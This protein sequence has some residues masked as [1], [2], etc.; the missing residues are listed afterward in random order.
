[1]KP[2]IKNYQTVH[3]STVIVTPSEKLSQW[4]RQN[5]HVSEFTHGPHRILSFQSWGSYCV[6]H[7]F[8]NTQMLLQPHQQLL[9]WVDLLRQHNPN[10]TESEYYDKAHDFGRFWRECHQACLH[11]SIQAS[12]Y[13]TDIKFLFEAYSHWL[14]SHQALD[15]STLFHDGM[16][17]MYDSKRDMPFPQVVFFG[18][19][20]LSPQ[21]ENHIQKLSEHTPCFFEY[22]I[23]YLHTH[24]HIRTSDDMDE[25]AWVA[26]CLKNHPTETIRIIVHDVTQ[27][28]AWSTYLRWQHNLASTAIHAQKLSALHDLKIIRSAIQVLTFFQPACSFFSRQTLLDFFQKQ[29]QHARILSRFLAH[30]HGHSQHCFAWEA[31]ERLLQIHAPEY[32]KNIWLKVRPSRMMPGHKKTRY[33]WCQWMK[34]TLQQLGWP[35]ADTLDSE[36]YQVAK[37]F[38]KMLDLWVSNIQNPDQLIDWHAMMTWLQ[39]MLTH[40]AYQPQTT[41]NTRIQILGPNQYQGQQTDV[42]IITGATTQ[43]FPGRAHCHPILHEI[44][45]TEH[46]HW[47]P[48]NH[49]QKSHHQYLS[50]CK[51][52]QCVYVTF[53]ETIHGT[54]QQPAHLLASLP[55]IQRTRHETKT[56]AV[57]TTLRPLTET[58]SKHK[59]TKNTNTHALKMQNLCSMR[60][61]WEHHLGLSPPIMPDQPSMKKTRGIVCHQVMAD[62]WGHVKTQKTLLKMGEDEIAQLID[63]LCHG[64]IQA[65]SQHDHW[66]QQTMVRRIEHQQLVKWISAFIEL[67]K[68]RDPFHVVAIEQEDTIFIGDTTINVRY[69]R[70]DQTD[71]GHVLLD[72][73]TGMA[74]PKQWLDDQPSDPQIP[75]YIQSNTYDFISADY[76][77]IQGKGVKILS[78]IDVVMQHYNDEENN[79]QQFKQDSHTKL[80]ACMDALHHEDARRNPKEGWQ[81][82]DAC[83][84][85]KL[86]RIQDMEIAP[87]V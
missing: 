47:H 71:Y 13:N 39:H 85:Q 22:P 78:G 76:A 64:A 49:N 37:Q 16:L 30:I 77:M 53:P 10:H 2:T 52:A 14:A 74:H 46:M 11:E 72:Y 8:F 70:I 84:F 20:D 17:S 21:Q 58:V 41:Q 40:T 9:L 23:Q 86:C 33:D 82:C 81:Q 34:N 27:I 87:H 83:S 51:S 26:Q 69:D 48:A 63:T 25:K 79:W 59:T 1:M 66:M 12:L 56:I 55:E 54:A 75:L 60:A 57:E 3:N 4:L 29:Q 5:S 35:F 42:L 7:V 61:F 65:C 6:R 43:N 44:T 28:Q 18:F 67:E 38:C 50:W 68:Q 73:K 62:F 19:H 32:H 45:P 31:L 24:G 80:E 15:N 36:T